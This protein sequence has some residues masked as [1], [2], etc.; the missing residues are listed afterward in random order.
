[1]GLGGNDTMQA[2]DLSVRVSVDSRVVDEQL[3]G[4]PA[5]LLRG[6]FQQASWVDAWLATRAEARPAMALAVVSDRATGAPLFVL[7]LM[8]DV[9]SGVPCWTALDDG[10]ADY[11]A[12]LFARDFDPPTQ[13]MRW[14]WAR[15]LDQLPKGDLVFL[16]KIPDRVAGRRNP[17]LELARPAPSRFRR[18][19]LAL[20]DG[21]AA[22]RARYRAGRTLARKRRKLCRK[23]H[24]DF[25]VLDGTAAVPELERLMTWR[26]RRYDTRPITTDFYGRLLRDTDMARLGLLRLDG[27]VISG[28][29]SVVADDAV[30]LLVVA[31]DERWKNWSPGLLAIDDMIGWTAAE[32]YAEFDFTIGSEPYKFDFGVATEPL[33]EIRESLRLRGS[34]ML[35]LLGARRVAAAL[36]R[37]TLPGF[38]AA[39]ARPLE[40]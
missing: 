39:P 19:P 4:M 3:R 20:V 18:H 31:F 5:D 6:P 37:R 14:I 15:I 40:G 32:G 1:M 11:N 12:P 10:V 34:L 17:M 25:V 30:R 2:M 28:C 8:L 23:G 29:F 13:T 9:R 27:E 35:S 24:L 21:I 22:V 7:P 33:W 36:A 26:G 38:G 16:E